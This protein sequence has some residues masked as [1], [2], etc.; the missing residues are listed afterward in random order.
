MR[1]R[2]GAP[3]VRMPDRPHDLFL[4][5]IFVVDHRSGRQHSVGVFSVA[6][7][8]VYLNRLDFLASW[9]SVVLGPLPLESAVVLLNL[10]SSPPALPSWRGARPSLAEA[11]AA[12]AHPPFCSLPPSSPPR[13]CIFLLAGFMCINVRL[14][15]RG[16]GLWIHILTDTS[17][18]PFPSRYQY[19]TKALS[20]LSTFVQ[21]DELPLW[22]A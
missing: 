15:P 22:A 18:A 19:F 10:R 11:G 4:G 17:Y 16:T 13:A 12:C 6:L 8:L 2:F 20:A 5:G 21:V 14:L 7:R 1:L 3:A 9:A